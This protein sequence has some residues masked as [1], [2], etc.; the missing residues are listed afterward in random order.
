MIEKVLQKGDAHGVNF[1][2]NAVCVHGDW[3]L[4][5]QREGK[6]DDRP[7]DEVV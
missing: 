1:D 5:L 7:T 3:A 2:F 6:C 4:I